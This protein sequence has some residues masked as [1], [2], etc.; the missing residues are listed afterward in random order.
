VKPEGWREVKRLF[1]DALEL[2][3]DKR[4][5]F[6]DRACA[7]DPQLRDA[8]GHDSLRFGSREVR[9]NQRR[10]GV[11]TMGMSAG[12]TPEAALILIRSVHVVPS[13]SR[14]HH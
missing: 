11:V 14:M 10:K 3:L 2:E 8:G 4:A 7:A 1:H 9:R 12:L 13:I 5:L 6:L